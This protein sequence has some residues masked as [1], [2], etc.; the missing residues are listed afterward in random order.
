MLG[1]ADRAC[2]EQTPWQLRGRLMRKTVRYNPMRGAVALR[3]P[4][5]W[6][7]ATLQL[8]QP[9]ARPGTM[10]ALLPSQLRRITG[11]SQADCEFGFEPDC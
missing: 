4:R 8:T 7:I 9:G 2:R 5:Q 11:P 10:V 1:C 6:A 3:A